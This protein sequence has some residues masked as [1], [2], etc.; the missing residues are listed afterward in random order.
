MLINFKWRAEYSS[1]DDVM[2]NQCC[3]SNPHA[4]KVVISSPHPENYV[5]TKTRDPEPDFVPICIDADRFW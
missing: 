5:M 4:T 2:E 1:T 3:S